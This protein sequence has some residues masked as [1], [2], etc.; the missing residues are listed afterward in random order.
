MNDRVRAHGRAAHATLAWLHGRR[1]KEVSMFAAP[2]HFGIPEPR[3]PEHLEEAIKSLL[4]IPTGEMLH[5]GGEACHH[6]VADRGEVR[7]ALE[8]S[9][10]LDP[11]EPVD[12]M[13]PIF[14]DLCATLGSPRIWHGVIRLANALSKH[15]IMLGDH[16]ADVLR[17]ATMHGSGQ[18]Y[19]PVTRRITVVHGTAR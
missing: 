12:A 16:V 17:G 7:R 11:A 5:L 3:T 4:S 15:R 6:I 18:P 9:R 19:V 2:T 8:L 10:R 1:P 14:D 13:E